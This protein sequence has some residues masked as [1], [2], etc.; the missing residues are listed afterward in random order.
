V[1]SCT[2]Q[3]EFFFRRNFVNARYNIFRFRFTTIF[4]H[5]M[6]HKLIYFIVNSENKIVKAPKANKQLRRGSGDVSNKIKVRKQ[7]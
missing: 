1:S 3:E 6:Q 7:L 4:S 5:I 2:S